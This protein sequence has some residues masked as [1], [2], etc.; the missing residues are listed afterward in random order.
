MPLPDLEAIAGIDPADP[1]YRLALD[2]ARGDRVFIRDLVAARRARMSREDVAD[3]LG[4]TVDAVAEIEAHDSD[5][6][7]SVLRRYAQVVGVRVYHHVYRSVLE[8]PDVTP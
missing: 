6:R 3:R 7:L 5:P 1:E 8:A 2:L 4:I